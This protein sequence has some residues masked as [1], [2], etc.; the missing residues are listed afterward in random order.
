MHQS[1]TN[2][3]DRALFVAASS[4]KMA[5]VKSH[6]R[7]RIM[8][9]QRFSRFLFSRSQLLHLQVQAN[10]QVAPCEALSRAA[11]SDRD[12]QYCPIQADSPLPL[13]FLT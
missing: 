13:R 2:S 10:P 3:V 6:T 5:R 4:P 9:A 1:S 7:S 8:D 11:Y 12:F